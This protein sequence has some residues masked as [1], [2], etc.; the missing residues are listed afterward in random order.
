MRTS[1]FSHLNWTGEAVWINLLTIDIHESPIRTLQVGSET[2]E[3]VGSLHAQVFAD[4]RVN[5][6]HRANRQIILRD[7]MRLDIRHSHRLH[8]TT[9]DT[10]KAVDLGMINRMHESLAPPP[11]TNFILDIEFMRSKVIHQTIS[12]RQPVVH[13]TAT[14]I[15]IASEERSSVIL[16]HPLLMRGDDDEGMVGVHRPLKHA[17]DAA[18]IDAIGMVCRK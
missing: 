8:D 14:F 10:I 13:E 6:P 5:R 3:A 1:S 12:L 2:L 7:H 18:R 16:A 9:S 11:A 17:I 4:L 15:K